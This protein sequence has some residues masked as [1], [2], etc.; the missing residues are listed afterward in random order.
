MRAAEHGGLETPGSDSLK[1]DVTSSAESHLTAVLRAVRGVNQLITREKDRGTLLRRACGILTETRGYGSAWIAVTD[2][3]G[4]V[5]QVDASGIGASFESLRERLMT[6]EWP[7]C[8]EQAMTSGA[9]TI[10]HDPKA[11]CGG[12]PLAGSYRDSAAV[13]A[14]LRHGERCYGVLV[15]AL[16]R[17][18]VDV[19]EERSLVGEAAGDLALAL[20]TFDEEALRRAAEAREG[21]LKQVLL[22]I[23][24][25]NQLIVHEDD[26]RRLIERACDNLTGTLGY[27]NAWIALLDAGGRVVTAT[28]SSCCGDRFESLRERLMS[29]TF[30]DC[31]IQALERDATLIVQDPVLTC[32]DCPLAGGYEGRAGF[33][34]RLAFGERIYGILAVSVPSE[35]ALDPEEEGLFEELAGDI[36]FALHKIEMGTRLREADSR[37]RARLEVILSPEGDI[38]EVSLADVI[39]FPAVQDLMNSFHGLTGIGMAIVDLQGRILVAT[40]W[41]DICT[42]FHRVHPET[43]KN[44]IESDTMLS[45]GVEPGSFRL[46]HCANHL[47]DIA[48]PIMLGDH[49]A[50]N[51]FLGQFL[52]EGE[53]PDRELFREQARRY[54]FDEAAYLA[55]LDRLPRWSRERVTRAMT[56]YAAFARQV[57]DLSYGNVK[58]ARTLTQRDTLH[59]R[60]G[61]NEE[62][63]S[64]A[65][66]ATNDVVWDWD[67]LRDAQMWNEAG[68]LVFGWTDIVESPQSAAWWVDRVHPEDRDRVDRGFF[69]AVL[70]PAADRW[71]DEYRFRRADGTYAHVEDRGYILR[72]GAGLALRMIGAMLDITDRKRAE[73]SLRRS[74][75]LLDATEEMS[76]VGGWEWEVE[77]A[78]LT[79]TEGTYRIHDMNPIELPACSAESIER[80]LACYDPGDR[81][82]VSEAFR[83]CIEDGYPYDM[84]CGFT[85]AAG[86][87]LRV[88]TMGRAIRE[89]GQV[90]RVIGNL[91]DITEPSKVQEELRRSREAFQAM[92]NATD[93]CVFLM[94]LESTVL[95][96]NREASRRMGRPGDDLT[97]Q[98][99]YDLLPPEI[100]EHRRAWVSEVARTG[101]PFRE[102]DQRGSLTL[103][104]MVYPLFDEDGN[105]T[106]VAVFSRD[107]SER[108]KAEEAL[109]VS[110]ERFR[111]ANDASLDCLL[112]LRSERDESG[113]IRDFVF[114]DLNRRAEEM[115]HMSRADLVGRRLCE[116]LP[117][118]REGGFFDKYKRVSETGIPLEEEFYLPETHV[119]AAWY[120]HQVVRVG[121][122]VFIVHSDIGERKK[123]EAESR[124][125]QAQ[126]LQAQKMESI[127]RL[128]GGVAHDFNNLLMGIMGYA[129]L[130][131]GEVEPEHPIRPWLEEILTETRRSADLT[132]QLLAFARKQVVQPRNL[133][134]NEQI[135]GML[136]MLGRLIG[137]HIELNWSPGHGLRI[138]LA[139]PAHID[140]ILANLCVNAADAIDGGGR[141]D[142]ATCNV[143][144]D[145]GDCARMPETEPGD[146]VLLTVSDD[147]C[148]IDGDSLPH[149]FEPF[150]TTKELGRGT[151]LGL[152][153]VYGIV[154]QSRGYIELVSTPGE[155]TTVR[156]FLPALDTGSA[157]PSPHGDG[158]RMPGGS[159]TILV[160]DDERSIRETIAVQLRGLGYDVLVADSPESALRLAQESSRP[161]D[162]LLTDIVMPGMSGIELRDRLLT[163]CPGLKT[164]LITGYTTA[165]SE[166]ER[167]DKGA[168]VH[169]TKPV[170]I[171]DLAIAIRS[172]LDSGAE[173]RP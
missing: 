158:G 91:Q 63:L 171:R 69:G 103:D 10:L 89:R 78:S 29:G 147:G 42:K 49:Q 141:V 118:N 18:E 159:E 33:T 120:Y 165:G 155:G 11:E 28:A 64:L 105:V 21:H 98:R 79:W 164:T 12:C 90:V 14:P 77:T 7:S 34:R 123:A 160:V 113:E 137:E 166:A 107:I 138:I 2:P 51:L 55:A 127:G 170:P 1:T 125:L 46:Y 86:R 173:P 97:G 73:D 6:G 154:K 13:A 172:L 83:R 153:T 37:V 60:L 53:E 30:S 84:E 130:C 152:A 61:E 47:W 93:D 20:H 143:V 24:N 71:S 151:G 135:G 23:R 25:V 157:E 94:D 140:Q 59:N 129:E 149:V 110:E 48:T 8:A 44:C 88:R 19:E 52:F 32:V 82:R 162:L 3:E 4:R 41:Q 167:S 161:I 101:R 16:P 38:G 109:R 35:Y 72:D 74:R 119:P 17:T 136:R 45:S 85:S 124:Q 115:L 43:L 122:G 156:V 168:T 145:A 146:Y 104:S 117:I 66:K 40:G 81:E 58:L 36:G 99:M 9:V 121:D 87:R 31:M 142:I 134:L 76:G 70:D 5:L 67:I 148:G 65:L 132:S 114:V 92:L 22:A 126:L 106:R 27:Y 62:R 133:D 139:D 128:A 116:E 39:D 57:S 111:S 100:A 80:S 56:F 54:G 144:L 75:S 68:A 102:E 169:L 112:L 163:L 96:H 50:G 95:A 131:R 26:P 15:V 108:K 150:F